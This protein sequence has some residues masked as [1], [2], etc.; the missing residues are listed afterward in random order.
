[1]RGGKI[2]N[3]RKIREVVK[4]LVQQKRFMAEYNTWKRKKELENIKKV[5]AKFEKRLSIKLKR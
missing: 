1:M 5:I 2:L 4:Y 3:K